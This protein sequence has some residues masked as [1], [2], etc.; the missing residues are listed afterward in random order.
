MLHVHK[1]LRC[2]FPFG[3]AAGTGGLKT[4]GFRP[5]TSSR[6]QR[7][8]TGAF[9]VQDRYGRRAQ[10]KKADAGRKRRKASSLLWGWH[11]WQ[12]PSHPKG[13]GAGINKIFTPGVPEDARLP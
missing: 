6:L 5:P 13:T 12:S 10:G 7:L 1:I 4:F 11:G 3:I 8:Q 9:I 2:V